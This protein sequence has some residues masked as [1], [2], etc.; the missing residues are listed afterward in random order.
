MKP[1]QE[2]KTGIKAEAKGK[3]EYFSW[4][5]GEVLLLL[6]VTIHYEAYKTRENGLNFLKC[7]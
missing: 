4:T 6:N 3:P 1:D 5:D 7:P 2:S